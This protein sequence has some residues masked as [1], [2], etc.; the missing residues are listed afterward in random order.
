[1]KAIR[2]MSAAIVF[3]AL[4]AALPTLQAQTRPAGQPA[5]TTRP[6]APATTGAPA[7]AS[8][9]TPTGKVAIIDSRA[10]TDEKEGINR[11]VNA[12]KSVYTQFQPMRTEL[13]NLSKQYEALV[14]QIQDQQK[15]PTD[16]R[17]LQQNVDRAEQMKK[18][19]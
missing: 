16:P 1:M 14:K 7:T 2:L 18:D 3:A 5:A 6:A 4:T 10:F 19:I 9:P 12:V 11:V 8:V 13:E 15:A 17:A